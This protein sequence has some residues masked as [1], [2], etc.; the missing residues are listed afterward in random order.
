MNLRVKRMIDTGLVE[1]VKTLLAEAKPLS[2]QARSAI[3]YAEIIN[4]LAGR[5]CLEEAVEQIK[6]DT[7]RLAKGQRTW[8]KTFRGVQ[9]LDI[10]PEEPAEQTVER[11]MAL[12][13]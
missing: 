8:F 13:R 7:R 2:R 9:W 3:G 10:Q 1:E 11:A 4:Y 12:W 6:K 5:T